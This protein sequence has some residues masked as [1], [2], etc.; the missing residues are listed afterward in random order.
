MEAADKGSLVKILMTITQFKPVEIP[1]A[2]ELIDC[3]LKE[4]IAS[5]YYILVAEV[6]GTVSGYICYGPTPLTESTWDIYWEA[7][8]PSSQGQGIGSLLIRAAEAEISKA[9]GSLIVIET[10]S[11]P[12]YSLTRD[13]YIK[14]GYCVASHIKD[15]YAPGDGRVTYI[16]VL[17]TA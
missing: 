12:S 14:H 4:G 5:G 10:S 2:E 1:V 8:R 3:Y 11:I 15:F 7:V 13:F 17:Q 6:E 9:G 16:K